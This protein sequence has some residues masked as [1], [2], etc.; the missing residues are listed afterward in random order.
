MDRLLAANPQGVP[1]GS[2]QLGKEWLEGSKMLVGVLN[3]GPLSLDFHLDDRCEDP[4]AAARIASSFQTVLA[5]LRAVPAKKDTASK[6]DFPTLLSTLTIRPQANSVLVDWQ[7]TPG[8]LM[9]VLA[10]LK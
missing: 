8:M 10:N 6:S 4:P 5:I 9:A 3:S 1:I 7:A 2:F